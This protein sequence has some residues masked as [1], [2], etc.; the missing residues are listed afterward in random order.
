MKHLKTYLTASI[1]A[2]SLSGCSATSGMKPKVSTSIYSDAKVVKI[3]PH[4]NDCGSL[5]FAGCSS[6]AAEWS[7]ESPNSVILTVGQTGEYFNMNKLK[8]MIDGEEHVLESSSYTDHEYYEGSG[9]K[10]SHQNFTMPFSTLVAL[11]TAKSA[12]MRVQNSKEY[13]DHIIKKG[14]REGWSYFAMKRFVAKVY[15]IKGS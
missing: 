7:E 11:S 14:D 12:V 6:L 13:S 5:L 15:E 4:S 1:V 10:S 9:T 8:L 2:F 3:M